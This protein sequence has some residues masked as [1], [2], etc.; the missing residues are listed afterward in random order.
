MPA[1]TRIRPFDS[2][3][4]PYTNRIPRG[5]SR[6]LLV[7]IA[8]AVLLLVP[9]V[10][11]VGSDLS[12]SAAQRD[13]SLFTFVES[14]KTETSKDATSPS[15]AIAEERT[16][17]VN[18]AA[19]GKNGSPRLRMQ[20]L[21]GTTHEA[22]R[23]GIESRGPG[24]FT[25]RGT[26]SGT[27]D[28]TLSVKNGVMSGLIYA[29]SGVY[30]VIPTSGPT[31]RLARVDQS[32]FSECGGALRPATE[33]L[34][35]AITSGDTRAAG[36]A[37]SA[38]FIE[39]LIVYTA[40]ARNEAGGTS[41]IQAI[42]QSAVDV[43]NSAYETSGITTR[44]RLAPIQEINYTE[45]ANSDTDLRWLT[46]DPTVAVLRN[47]LGG[48]VV[49]MFV[50]DLDGSG[51][52]GWRMVQVGSGFAPSAFNVV[53][54]KGAVGNL[55]F[56]HEV[57]HNQGCDHDVAN[58]DT[59]KGIAFPYAYGYNDT[60]AG[61]HTVM[62]Y[63][64][65]GCPDCIRIPR[66]SNPSGRY[67]DVRTGI[68]YPTG[69]TGTAENFRVINNT[70]SVVA[71]F[72]VGTY[73]LRGTPSNLTATMTSGSQIDL[74]WR[75]NTVTN[76][77][78]QVER[79][80]ENGPFVP[81]GT[82]GVNQ[83]RFSDAT[84]AE[85]NI[86]EYRVRAVTPD[87]SRFTDYS[88]DAIVIVGCLVSETTPISLGETVSGAL[89]A[90]DCRATLRLNG[91]R[92]PH[93][94]RYTFEGVQGQQ[95]ALSM[96]SAGLD[97]YL[98]LLDADGAEIASNDDG[99]VI[100]MAFASDSRIPASAE[101]LALP[102]T[103]TYIIEAT[104]FHVTST[105]A[106]TVTIIGEEPP[107]ECLV[108][109]ATPVSLGETAR[110]A[111]EASDCRSTVRISGRSRP[112]ADRYTFEGVEGQQVALSM[113]SAGFDT[114]LYLL[115]ADGAVITSN[116]DGDVN[117]MAFPFDSRIPERAERLTLPY[118]GTYIIEATGQF[119]DSTGAYT[120]TLIGDDPA[121]PPAA[122]SDLTASAITSEQVDLQWSDNSTD[123]DGFE[124]V[125][126]DGAEW[127][128]IQTVDADTT[129]VT[130]AQLTPETTY[131]FSVR[132]ID[133][134]GDSEVAEPVEV[135]TEP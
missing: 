133:V 67:V 63:R 48:D 2:R 91:N 6:S 46:N 61:F 96:S 13:T 109:E 4:G 36:R 23:T 7:R 49:S 45:S 127:T 116:D 16:V 128:P 121:V 114:Y 112:Y 113:S 51:G 65:S 50:S 60:A 47:A 108:S 115:D 54:M 11:F 43:T 95:V 56:A 89:E 107:V 38:D 135:T 119:I 105:G 80:I 58:T 84:V 69:R 126:W 87:R 8:V 5:R 57:G 102:Y 62:S 120:V 71:N 118:T 17:K 82:T 68:P 111:L 90:S 42:A 52:R 14:E 59:T 101:R 26:I 83:V 79:R 3:T 27:G 103:G 55:A 33:D 35:D 29:P 85:G 64:P 28:V 25:W 19:L 18:L 86:C 22:V 20:L 37:D 15:G 53:D 81:V 88:N 94:D 98:Y 39:I 9:G 70:A 93:A 76:C 77:V 31:H 131:L 132:A 78:F 104:G 122:P 12:V 72:R 40:A 10:P 123:E 130:I 97:A 75:D 41:Q 100:D 129:A 73:R 125:S 124:V 66:F 110:G 106:Y 134:N 117:G 99:D 24:D 1:S 32:R 21:D 34:P 30:Q 44:L 92:R 74:T